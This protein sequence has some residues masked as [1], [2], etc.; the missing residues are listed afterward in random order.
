MAEPTP[1]SILFGLPLLQWADVDAP[2]YD[3]API[4]VTHSQAERRFPYVDGASHDWTGRDPI[5]MNT[6]LYFMNTLQV[7][8]FPDLWDKWRPNLLDGRVR[9]LRHPILGIVRS[10]VTAFDAEVNAN[11]TLSGITVNVSW[12]ESLEDPA[13]AANFQPVFL[14]PARLAAAAD[15]ALDAVGIN[16]PEGGP[17]NLADLFQQ[18][19]GFIF[20]ANSAINGLINQAKGTITTIVRQIEFANDPSLHAPLGILKQLY[21]TTLDLEINLGGLVSRSTSTVAFP[22]PSTFE[23]IARETKNTVVELMSL[24]LALLK[25]PQ[26]PPAAVIKFYTD[27]A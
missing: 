6:R 25:S 15:S 21:A 17:A 11:Q 24:N 10:R 16:F 2:P 3:I 4:S 8:A 13:E 19:D 12:V 7:G 1:A 20:S 18:I 9:D 22:F 23:A 27:A 5:I 14:N 26:I